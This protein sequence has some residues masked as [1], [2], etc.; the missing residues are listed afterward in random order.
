MNASRQA[1]ASTLRW[2][3]WLLI[4]VLVISGTVF[5]HQQNSGDAIGGTIAL[6]KLIWLAIALWIW[7]ALPLLLAADRRLSP[8]LRLAYGIA[9]GNMVLRAI[10]ELWMMYGSHTWHPYWGIAHD[11]FSAAL[12]GG[13]LIWIKGR[14]LQLYSFSPLDTS[15]YQNLMVT[16]GMFLVEIYFAGYMLQNVHL[17]DDPVYF[18]PGESQ[19]AGILIVTWIVVV[20]LGVQQVLVGRQWWT[21][22]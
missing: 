14:S 4:A 10:A 12:I 9:W 21:A 22:K 20:C 11:A 1:P 16:G 13:L 18:V 5:Y 2:A 15:L 7:Y 19:Y 6:P 3:Y 17:G 8:P